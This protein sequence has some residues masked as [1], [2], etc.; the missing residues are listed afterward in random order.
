MSKIF[1]LGLDGGTFQIIDTLIDENMLP[2]FKKIKKNGSYGVLKSII[3]PLTPQAWASFIT[4]VNPGKHGLFDFGEMKEGAYE[5]QLV[6]SRTRQSKTIWHYLNLN[7]K[8]IIVLNIPLTYPIEKVKGIFISGMHTPEFKKGVYPISLA[9]ELNE[10]FSNYKIDVMS[11]WYN[12]PHD[13]IKNI[14]L[15]LKERIKLIKYLLSKYNPDLMIAVIIASD[16]VQHF[17]WKQA[18]INRKQP[19]N[20]YGK[21]LEEIY[22][23]VDK[24]IGEIIEFQEKDDYFFIIS[25]H[26][27]GSLEK[28]VNLNRFLIENGYLK[29]NISV[30]LNEKSD[31]EKLF[32]PYKKY[33]PFITKFRFLFKIIPIKIWKKI[34]KKAIEKGYFSTKYQN[35]HTVDWLKTKAYS[36]GLFGGIYCNLEGREPL[37]IIKRGKEFDDLRYEIV[38]RLIC[39][40]DPEDKLPV[41]SKVYRKEELYEGRSIW[42]APDLVVVMRNW[43]YIT[44]GGKEFD[45]FQIIHTPTINHTGNHRL[46]G[47]F[48]AYGNNIKKGKEIKNISLLDILPTL[49]SILNIEVPENIDGKQIRSI[50]RKEISVQFRRYEEIKEEVKIE[51]VYP[52]KEK[53]LIENRLKSIGYF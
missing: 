28:E 25:D 29:F 39:L 4:G 42:K 24:L 26:G 21:I 22:I 19:N 11:F 3:H 35:F 38:R 16:R 13:F 30:L 52:E 44:R 5:L 40:R 50:F 41:V 6:T 14:K 34:L 51:L 18:W 27:F 10:S 48:F 23:T 7:G 36:F 43:S 2:N 45:S 17:L 12:N 46:D 53:Q 1:V 20:P 9:N 37:G 32:T 47:I 49:L 33:Y 8:S 31:L 15:M